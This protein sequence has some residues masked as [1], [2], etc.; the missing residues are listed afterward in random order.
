MNILDK[1]KKNWNH[2]ESVEQNVLRFNN[3]QE[4]RQR[5]IKKWYPLFI[6]L[7]VIAC[8]VFPIN[9][10][11][12]I[13]LMFGTITFGS[14]SVF[15][16]AETYDTFIAVLDSTHFVLVYSS[17]GY[18]SVIGTISGS[19]ISYGSEYTAPGLAYGTID[20]LDSTHFVIAYRGD[21][22]K[23]TCVIGTVSSGNEISYGT[24]V[25]FDT[26]NTLSTYKRAAI[27]KKISSTSFIVLYMVENVGKVVIGTVSSGNTINYGSVSN[28]GHLSYADIAVLDST[29]FVIVFAD[30]LGG[31]FASAII[32]TMSGNSI[33]GYGPKSTFY[34]QK[35]NLC[36]VEKIDSTHFIVVFNNST[37]YRLQCAIA[38]RSSTS[39]SYGDIYEPFS[40]TSSDA[41]LILLDS[42]HFVLQ[43]ENQVK[44]GIISNT[45][46][47]TFETAVGFNSGGSI[48]YS[49]MYKISDTEFVLSYV[50]VN[51]SNY[52]TVIIGTNPPPIVAPT[53]TTQ[54]ADQ[55]ATTSIRG[56]GN[57]TDTGGENCT[58]RGFC[59]KEGTT[60]DPTT[61]DSV[62]YDDGSF[63]TGA[64]TKSITGLTGNTS[65]RVRAY[66]TNSDGTGYGETVQVTTI[67]A[68]K[69]RTMWF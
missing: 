53:V 3:E 44:L 67:K 5:R 45:D 39:I 4:Q 50:D 62:A 56:N 63:G 52:G 40:G 1:I 54:A 48:N 68:F 55:I 65:Y 22:G 32:G 16:S 60:G 10:L 35:Y 8:L 58:R 64:F 6:G 7:F 27:V 25:E 47:I 11:L 9:P 20:V 23:G 21:T 26:S 33:T 38:T 49:G 69:P 19:S 51:N 66:A 18:K 57:I 15:K 13:C 28:T 17:G 30:W 12:G 2:K 42:T 46:E 37:T 29:H 59:Y 43:A 24:A 34:R 61:S 14:E 36:R 41:N 31:Y